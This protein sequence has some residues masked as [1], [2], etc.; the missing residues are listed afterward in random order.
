MSGVCVFVLT[1]VGQRSFVK[2]ACRHLSS[3]HVVAVC[4]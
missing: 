3:C 4:S 2:S 1:N